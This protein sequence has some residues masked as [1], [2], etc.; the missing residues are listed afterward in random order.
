MTTR[1]ARL[2]ALRKKVETSLAEGQKLEP[3]LEG[4]GEPKVQPQDPVVQAVGFV[5]RVRA[6][7]LPYA[8]SSPAAHGFIQEISRL[9]ISRTTHSDLYYGRSVLVNDFRVVLKMLEHFGADLR[10][11]TGGRPVDSR[12]QDVKSRILEM[13]AA[14]YTHE[15]I[16]RELGSS[17]RPHGA[18]WRPLPW[19]EAFRKDPVSV[20]VWIS[21]VGKTRSRR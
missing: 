15:E 10:S 12:M 4:H 7:I 14:N 13:L 16:C 8:A 11:G 2:S 6:A 21:K 19:P 17:P 9:R 18:T 3:Q 5:N 20:K 1:D